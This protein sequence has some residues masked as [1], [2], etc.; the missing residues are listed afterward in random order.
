MQALRLVLANHI[1]RVM[2]TEEGAQL[3]VEKNRTRQA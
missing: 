1:R 3:A 2:Q